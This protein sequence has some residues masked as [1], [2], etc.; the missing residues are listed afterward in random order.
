[1]LICF[2]DSPIRSSIDRPLCFLW[3]CSI[4][5]PYCFLFSFLLEGLGVLSCCSAFNYTLRRTIRFPSK[6]YCVVLLLFSRFGPAFVCHVVSSFTH[7]ACAFYCFA[8]A[9]ISR[10]FVHCFA[11]S[12]HLQQRSFH[13]KLLHFVEVERLYKRGRRRDTVVNLHF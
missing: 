11:S 10:I 3:A 1:M 2:I 9:L 7:A 6:E 5:E 13:L 4:A 8:F 12:L